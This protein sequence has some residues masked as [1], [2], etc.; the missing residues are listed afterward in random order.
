MRITAGGVGVVE[1]PQA[2]PAAGLAHSCEDAARRVDDGHEAL[3]R[4]VRG[5]AAGRLRAFPERVPCLGCSPSPRD[6]AADGGSTRPVR[7]PSAT[8]AVTMRYQLISLA[9]AAAVAAGCAIW[10]PGTDP[11][12][13]DLIEN[14][15]QLVTSL[16][17]F[18]SSTGHYPET[19]DE[20]PSTPDL[21][22]P[23][24]NFDFHYE[25]NR[26]GYRLHLNYT[27]SWPQSGRV[28]CC[29]AP[30]ATGWGCSGYL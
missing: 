29:F 2:K 7:R 14:G 10:A 25:P 20:L 24:T 12:G 1:S 4:Q 22:A 3:R 27:P 18:R 28:S 26:E 5:F 9:L 30:G 16:E 23:G 6:A 19:L 11:R 15:D 8:F 13:R 17:A 21:G